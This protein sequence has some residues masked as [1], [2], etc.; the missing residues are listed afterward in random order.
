MYV[1]SSPG[2]LLVEDDTEH[3]EDADGVEEAVPAERPPVEV[4]SGAGEQPTHGDDEH[5]VEHGG[6]DHAGH[7]DVVLG[8]EHADDDS[9]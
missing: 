2:D 9:G 6:P 7:S 3:D 4:G 1:L 5:D 8:E